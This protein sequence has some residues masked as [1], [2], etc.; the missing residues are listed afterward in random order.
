VLHPMPVRA[1]PENPLYE[2]PYNPMIA[3]IPRRIAE[4]AVNAMLAGDRLIIPGFRNKISFLLR[5]NRSIWFRLPP[6]SVIPREDWFF[7]GAVPSPQ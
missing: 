4:K 2:D 3:M 1:V 5:R 7:N 6:V